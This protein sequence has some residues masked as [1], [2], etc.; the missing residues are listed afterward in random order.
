MINDFYLFDF[1]EDKEIEGIS[2]MFESD[3]KIVDK[4]G[5]YVEISKVSKKYIKNNKLEIETILY[6]SPFKINDINT[7]LC[8]IKS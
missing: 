2:F 4:D 3:F 5:F 8:R 7:I 1:D 6:S